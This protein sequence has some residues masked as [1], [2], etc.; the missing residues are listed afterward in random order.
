MRKPHE[1]GAFNRLA[2]R[3][4]PHLSPLLMHRPVDRLVR[5]AGIYLD[6]LQGKGAGTGWDL[7]SEAEVAA[8]F[9]LRPRPVIFDI[10]ANR[11]DWSA[12]LLQLVGA[13]DPQLYLF[14]P[15]PACQELIR[16][17]NLPRAVIVPAAVGERPGSTELISHAPGS[18]VASLY[19]RRDTYHQF[20]STELRETVPVVNVDT[21]MTK[22]AIDKVDFMKV[23]VEGHE[24]AVLSGARQALSSKRIG[25]LSF[26]F[27]SGQINSRNF[28]HDFWDLLHP[29]GYRVQRICPGGVLLEIEEYYEDLEHFRGVSNYLAVLLQESNRL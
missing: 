22:Y 25:A 24:L 16:A 20:A 29:L 13:Y 14:E 21:I 8:R 18:P 4:A 15:Q 12:A 28:F 26:E 1:D 6:I 10:G 5:M 11:G 23:D 19:V 9:I 2:K 7:R 27:G 3:L 17:R